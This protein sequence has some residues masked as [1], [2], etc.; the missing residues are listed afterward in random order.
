M[1]CVKSLCCPSLGPSMHQIS[2]GN[3]VLRAW[4][5]GMLAA[6]PHL[7]STKA[8]LNAKKKKPYAKHVNFNVLQKGKTT[9]ILLFVKLLVSPNF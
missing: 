8:G 5:K 1:L 2:D 7:N 6:W 3:G 4:S 9:I